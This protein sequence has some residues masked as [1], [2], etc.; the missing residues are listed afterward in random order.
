MYWLIPIALVLFL[1]WSEVGSQ[2]CSPNRGETLGQ[3]HNRVEPP[4]PMSSPAEIID[5][6]ILALRKNHTLVGW[7]RAMMIALISMLILGL[8]FSISGGSFVLG[9][10]IIFVVA[11]TLIGYYQHYY[12]KPVDLEIEDQ[13][14]PLRRQWK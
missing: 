11:Y 9:T 13:L 3:C 10:L 1:C 8:F 12:W 5:I 7:R 2:D 14:R 6:T 4:L